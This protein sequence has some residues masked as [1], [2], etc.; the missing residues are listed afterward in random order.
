MACEPGD[1]H[2]CDTLRYYLCLQDFT[3][4][5]TDRQFVINGWGAM[6]RRG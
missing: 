4:E 6:W 1:P 3:L 2:G 5:R